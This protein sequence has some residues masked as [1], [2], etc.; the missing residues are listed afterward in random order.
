MSI[1]E[2][3]FSRGRP[4]KKIKNAEIGA[5]EVLFR[6]PGEGPYVNTLVI[7]SGG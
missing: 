7:V 6:R 2:R 1:R 3:W 4:R 5:Q